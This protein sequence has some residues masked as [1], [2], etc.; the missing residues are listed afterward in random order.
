[1][2]LGASSRFW[3]FDHMFLGRFCLQ[4]HFWE[5]LTFCYVIYY[6]ILSYYDNQTLSGTFQLC[7]R[8]SGEF[9]F[10]GIHQFLLVDAVHTS[11]HQNTSVGSVPVFKW[12][13]LRGRWWTNH[14]LVVWNIWIIFPY[15]GNFIISTDEL[16]HFS[17][18]FCSKPPT[19]LLLT[20]I[21]HHHNHIIT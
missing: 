10:G 17:E 1:M 19:R 4:F 18:G 20:I 12:C 2:F 5:L 7:W 3:S 16:H 13:P 21:N 8:S 9:H 14:W 15:I 6:V 11:P